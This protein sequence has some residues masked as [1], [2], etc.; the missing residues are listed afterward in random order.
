MKTL[1]NL[2]GTKQTEKSICSF[3]NTLNTAAM[4]QIRGGENDDDC[5]LWPPK[6]DTVS[7][8]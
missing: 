2:F 3:V 6:V 5:D 4:I 8:N 7:G 1:K